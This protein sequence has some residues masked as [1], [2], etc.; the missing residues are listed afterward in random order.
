MKTLADFGLSPA[1]V[2]R[3]VVGIRE[4][5]GREFLNGLSCAARSARAA[6]ALP[7]EVSMKEW[8]LAEARRLGI[9]PSG[10]AMRL[11]KGKYPGL[12]LRV[13]NARRVFVAVENQA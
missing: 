1:T 11:S 12:R 8:R 3:F 4:A 5:D 9:G 2:R 13:A 7:G 6:R 10:V